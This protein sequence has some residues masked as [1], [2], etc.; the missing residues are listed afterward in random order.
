MSTIMRPLTRGLSDSCEDSAQTSLHCMLS[1]AAPDHSGAYFS[2]SSVLYRDKQCK[3][4]GYRW[5]HPTPTPLTWKPQRSWLKY[6]DNSSVWMDER[7]HRTLRMREGGLTDPSL[8]QPVVTPAQTSRET[9]AHTDDT[10]PIITKIMQRTSGTRGKSFSLCLFLGGKSRA[11]RL[12]AAI[13][14]P[15]ASTIHASMSSP[16]NTGRQSMARS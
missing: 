15:M 2:Q 11:A 5:I 8:N 9:K 4:G 6:R 16:K 3:A 13:A 1:D 12:P 14:P 10:V 7:P